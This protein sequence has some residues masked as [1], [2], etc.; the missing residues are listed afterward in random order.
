MYNQ[1]SDRFISQ[2]TLKNENTL[3]QVIK[4]LLCGSGTVSQD[5]IIYHRQ[6]ALGV[7]LRSTF[8]LSSRCLEKRRW[9]LV[10]TQYLFACKSYWKNW[11]CYKHWLSYV[12]ICNCIY[13]CTLC[14]AEES[15]HTCSSTTSSL[16]VSRRYAPPATASPHTHSNPHHLPTN[17]PQPQPIT[18]NPSASPPSTQ[19][20]HSSQTKNHVTLNNSI[21]TTLS[22]NTH[23][24]ALTN[25]SVCYMGLCMV[26]CMFVVCVYARVVCVYVRGYDRLCICVLVWACGSR[27]CMWACVCVI[28]VCVCLCA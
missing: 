16:V 17:S 7:F 2:I 13:S 27:A 11:N 14:H 8:I 25:Y 10:L 4:S 18:P 24:T 23:S 6:L 20:T 3:E 22:L 26:E 9:T 1:R 19:N 5:C 12:V 15:N 28:F 21:P